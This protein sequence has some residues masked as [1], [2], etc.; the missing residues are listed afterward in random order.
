MDTGE[1]QSFNPEQQLL[2]AAEIAAQAIDKAKIEC[3]IATEDGPFYKDVDIKIKSIALNHLP[4][5]VRPDDQKPFFLEL[6]S[7][8]NIGYNTSELYH[9]DKGPRYFFPDTNEL[10]VLGKRNSAHQSLT[11]DRKLSAEDLSN[12][13]R[14]ALVGPTDPLYDPYSDSF[15]GL[16]ALRE[17]ADL[18][19]DVEF[20]GI[21][22][23]QELLVEDALQILEAELPD[24]VLSSEEE[25][26][27]KDLIIQRYNQKEEARE[28]NGNNIQYRIQKIKDEIV[29]M[30]KSLISDPVRLR[31]D[32]DDIYKE[33]GLIQFVG[34]I[35][36]L[37]SGKLDETITQLRKTN[38]YLWYLPGDN[39]IIVAPKVEFTQGRFFKSKYWG[40]DLE[41]QAETPPAVWCYTGEQILHNLLRVSGVEKGRLPEDSKL[42]DYLE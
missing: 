30:H 13:V 22:P 39:K 42:R 37:T 11:K 2:T 33:E 8:N 20:K 32:H 1:N 12:A 31:L 17:R 29:R 24:S 26:Q 19:D 23:L 14:K 16:E 40:P 41:Q 3:E 6:A 27:I 21:D 38:V 7:V 5:A 18:P 36:E 15:I 10:L 28:Q 9:N 34:E 25:A 35:S 4:E